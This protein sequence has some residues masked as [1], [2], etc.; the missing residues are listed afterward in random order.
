MYNIN[1][2]C[3]FVQNSSIEVQDGFHIAEILTISFWYNIVGD[4][5]GDNGQ[6]KKDEF[7]KI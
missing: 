2:G 7:E 4:I 1:N 6:E 3:N 5:V